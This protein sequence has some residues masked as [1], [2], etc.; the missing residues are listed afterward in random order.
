[1]VQSGL[2]EFQWVFE[3]SFKGVSMKFQECFKEDL[4]VFQE[5]FKQV[6]RELQGN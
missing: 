4:G 1:M 6:S 2:K 5:T 3:G